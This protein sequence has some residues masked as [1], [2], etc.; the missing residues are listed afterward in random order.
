MRKTLRSW[1]FPIAASLAGAAFAAPPA[2]VEIAYEVARNGAAIAEVV[3]RLEHDG[4]L[5]RLEE[6]WK[7]KGVYALRGEAKRTSRGAVAGKTLR[8]FE[9]E[10]RRTGRDTARALFGWDAKTLTLQHKGGPETRPLPPD[11]QDR[12]S[13]LW[14]LAFDPPG[15]R[16]VS[17]SVA[18][19][20]GVSTYVYQSAGRERIRTPAGAFDAL[21]LV[22]K[23]EGADARGS[24]V[25]LAAD[26]GHVPVR[27]VVT[28]K[29]G[30]RLEQVAVRIAAP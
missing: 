28:E 24:E 2:R 27:I 14:S 21:R 11:A 4:R 3:D 8:P 19:G 26:R 9:F 13:F 5:Y 18:D 25:W 22:K 1:C 30:T 20:R 7:G 17:M 15:A 16:P 12:L 23:K 29:D 6:T 10:D